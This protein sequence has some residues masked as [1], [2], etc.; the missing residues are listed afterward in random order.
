MKFSR[1]NVQFVA[2]AF[3]VILLLGVWLSGSCEYDGMGGPPLSQSMK[4]EGFSENLYSSAMIVYKEAFESVSTAV[5]DTA[6]APKF[7]EFCKNQK[8]NNPF[9]NVAAFNSG[10]KS[11]LRN[12]LKYGI[13]TLNNTLEDSFYA[14]FKD[15]FVHRSQRVKEVVTSFKSNPN[16][17]SFRQ[18]LIKTTEFIGLFG[19]GPYEFV[20]NNQRILP[21]I[22]AIIQKFTD[23]LQQSNPASFS[24]SGFFN[25]NGA[26]PTSGGSCTMNL[27]PFAPTSIQFDPSGN[28][29][30]GGSGGSITFDPSGNAIA[31]GPGANQ[32][33]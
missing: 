4:Y 8:V 28:P 11:S 20:Q 25:C 7:R 30:P 1:S 19:S 14:T 18:V 32:P 2:A 6:F 12:D 9:D 31:A 5:N 15:D 10:V 16:P 23:A 3:V 27:N 22:E 29:I 24:F 26:S 17:D 33:K 13:V 21:R